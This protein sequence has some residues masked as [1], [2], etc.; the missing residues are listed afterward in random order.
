VAF[1]QP[2]RVGLLSG[3][4]G[5]TFGNGFSLAGTPPILISEWNQPS[6]DI[7]ANGQKG[8]FWQAHLDGVASVAA[9]PKPSELALMLMELVGA[10]SVAR[11][12]RKTTELHQRAA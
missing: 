11:R 2:D 5:P 6:Y 9:V 7:N 10:G 8:A 12:R 3:K 1:R 4:L